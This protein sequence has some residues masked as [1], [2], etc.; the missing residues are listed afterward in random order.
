MKQTKG[1]RSLEAYRVFP[2]IAWGLVI[3]FSIFV[4]TIVSNLQTATSQLQHQ[5][6]ALQQQISS[7]LKTVDFDNYRE[8]RYQSGGNQE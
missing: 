2:Y 8:Q 3:G 5:T 1:K 4:Y 7:D 6:D